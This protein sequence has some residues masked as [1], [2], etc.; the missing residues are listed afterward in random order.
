MDLGLSKFLQLSNL[1]FRHQEAFL[2]T[3]SARN[4]ENPSVIKAYSET[5]SDIELI[6]QS[7]YKYLKIC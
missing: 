2:L 5:G 4:L 3:W 7:L 6:L 1:K